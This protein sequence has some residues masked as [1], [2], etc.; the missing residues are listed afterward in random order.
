MDK[1]RPA[2]GVWIETM[3]TID[4]TPVLNLCMGS[5][6]GTATVNGGIHGETACL[7]AQAA[8]LDALR[9]GRKISV[10]TDK[11]EC[12]CP[13]LRL[14]AIRIN[15]TKWWKSDE[16]R[17]EVLRPL[18]PLLLDSKVGLKATKRRGL[19]YVDCYV[20]E[21]VPMILDQ[22]NQKEAARKLRA[23][24]P[25]IDEQT[26][27]S[28]REVCA[29]LSLALDLDLALDLAR[30]LARARARAIALDLALDRVLAR[31]LALDRALDRA[32]ALDLRAKFI[33]L[34]KELAAITDDRS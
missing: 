25:I 19:R 12:A 7:V 1:S 8:I 29:E 32:L 16:E 2:R 17:T 21:I 4:L 13:I 6:V 3:K 33:E 20:R 10:P 22:I 15:D 30:A 27:L 31:A 28:A 23:L 24:L 26:I 18:I 5:G 34:F 14:F 9:S 11:L